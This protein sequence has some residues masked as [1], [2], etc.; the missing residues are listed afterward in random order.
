M[1]RIV[2][3]EA[4]AAL[5]LEMD[6]EEATGNE[7][8]AGRT[9]RLDPSFSAAEEN[10][11]KSPGNGTPNAASETKPLGPAEVAAA[12]LRKKS[13]A[14]LRDK[15]SKPARPDKKAPL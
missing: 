10:P 9:W 4:I 11:A 13:F 15:A 12:I 8:E 3:E 2:S 14:W 5:L 1:P 7:S 6:R